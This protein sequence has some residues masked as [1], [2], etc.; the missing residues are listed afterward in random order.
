ML[1]ADI[2][3]AK[4]DEW[5]DRSQNASDPELRAAYTILAITYRKIGTRLGEMYSAVGDDKWSAT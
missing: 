1:A 4:A 5:N 2:Y 3:F